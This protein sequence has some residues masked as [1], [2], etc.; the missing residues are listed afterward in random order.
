MIQPKLFVSSKSPLLFFVVLCPH[1][2][3]KNIIL[4][5]S[6][7]PGLHQKRFP[8]WGLSV[9]GHRFASCGD[10]RDKLPR[11]PLVRTGVHI[12]LRTAEVRGY[13]VPGAEHG[14][15]F[16]LAQVLR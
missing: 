7:S 9:V 12:D 13:A 14:A 15:C 4:S 6:G 10:V 2:A 5:S 8:Y 16:E 3:N 1:W 11:V